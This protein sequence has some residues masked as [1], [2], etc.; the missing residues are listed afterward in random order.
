M[1]NEAEY[2]NIIFQIITSNEPLKVRGKTI[3]GLDILFI[4]FYP[5]FND[6]D[7][8]E[9]ITKMI[10]DIKEEAKNYSRSSYF[11]DEFN[12][13]KLKAKIYV[14]SISNKRETNYIR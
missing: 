2:N 8:K 11:N 13:D 4:N 7:K 1:L 9:F 12:I 10:A 5:D 6:N 14:M 3:S